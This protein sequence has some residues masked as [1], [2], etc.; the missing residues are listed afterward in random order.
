MLS[1]EI[2][3]SRGGYKGKN[4]LEYGSS[5]LGISMTGLYE[6]VSFRAS[7]LVVAE[8]WPSW[9]WTLQIVQWD[10]IVVVVKNRLCYRNIWGSLASNGVEFSSWSKVYERCRKIDLDGGWVWIKS[11]MGPLFVGVAG[12]VKRL[13]CWCEFSPRK[14]SN[15]SSED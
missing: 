12:V 9:L 10:K 5:Q 8:T 15:M 2:L 11:R 7:V 14:S 1:E 13:G 4:Q 6:K 3:S